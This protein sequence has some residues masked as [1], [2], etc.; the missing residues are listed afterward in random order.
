VK[1]HITI[2]ATLIRLTSGHAEVA[3]I[4]PTGDRDALRRQIGIVFQ[5]PALD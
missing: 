3:G 5:E 2:L 1:I 4:S